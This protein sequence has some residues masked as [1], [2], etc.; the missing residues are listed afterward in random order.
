[1]AMMAGMQAAFESLMKRFNPEE[2][3][4][5]FDTIAGGRVFKS[6]NKAKYWDGLVE[7]YH[8]QMRNSDE[9]FKR[10]FGEPF[11]EAYEA[12]MVRLTGARRRH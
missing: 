5:E 10:L 8:K 2:L 12:Q 3:Q 4:R 6:L 11:A 1:M 9:S 7:L